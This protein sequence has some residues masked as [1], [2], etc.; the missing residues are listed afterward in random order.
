MLQPLPTPA[1]GG[2]ER[3]PVS[4]ACVRAA[5]GGK[6]LLRRLTKAT[7]KRHVFCQTRTRAELEESTAQMDFRSEEKTWLHE[8]SWFR[9][10]NQCFSGLFCTVWTS[11]AW[12][13]G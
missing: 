6:S 8:G 7:L 4:G 9:T 3:M 2:E 5:A 12:G 10:T 13:T 11:F 1:A